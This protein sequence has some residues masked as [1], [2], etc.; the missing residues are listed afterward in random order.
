MLICIDT[1]NESQ[2]SSSVSPCFSLIRAKIDLII[3]FAIP[4]E[5]KEKNIPNAISIYVF[6]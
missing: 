4:E 6:S 3:Q 1:D 5:K 2:N